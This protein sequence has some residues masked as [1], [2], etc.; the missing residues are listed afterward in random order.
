MAGFADNQFL[1]T[2]SG[3]LGGYALSG[4][5]VEWALMGALGGAAVPKLLSLAARH[6]DGRTPL[7]Q[8]HIDAHVALAYIARKPLNV[9]RDKLGDLGEGFVEQLK[10]ARNDNDR[11]LA[12]KYKYMR[13]SEMQ[14]KARGYT[15]EAILEAKHEAMEILKGNR[16]A[17]SNK[18]ANGMVRDW[19]KLMDDTLTDAYNSGIIDTEKYAR[20]KQ[21]ANQRGYFPRVYDE[22]FLNSEEGQDA[23]VKALSGKEVSEPK[24]R[25]LLQAVVGNKEVESQVLSK[26]QRRGGKIII[27]ENFAKIMLQ[28]RRS[29]HVG[30][31]SNHLEK[32]RK[33][34]S[35]FEELLA[36]FLVKDP[37]EA[38]SRYLLDSGNRINH[39]K[40][41]GAK[42]EKAH[43]IFDAIGKQYGTPAMRLAEEIYYARV[44]DTLST[45]V[46]AAVEMNDTWRTINGRVDAFETL[47]LAMGQVT[48]A[49][50]VPINASVLAAKLTGGSPKAMMKMWIDMADQLKSGKIRGED[51]AR[52]GAN[53]EATLM[54]LMGESGSM[55]HRIMGK[56]FSDIH[57]SGGKIFKNPVEYLN[58]PTEFLKKTGFLTVEDIN[59]ALASN[60]GRG[61]GQQLIDEMVQ[62]RKVGT[63]PSKRLIE[64]MKELGMDPHANSWGRADLD[65]AGLRFSDSVNFRNSPGELPILW[66]HPNAQ[67]FRKFKSFA[68]NHASFL[69]DNIVRPLYRKNIQGGAGAAAAYAVIGGVTGMGVDEV[70]RMVKGDDSDLTMTER[71]VRGV[72]AAG[73][74]GIWMDLM[75]SYNPLTSALGPAASDLD[76]LI[77]EGKQTVAG[78]QGPGKMISDLAKGTLVIPYEKQLF[79][80]INDLL[81][82]D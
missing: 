28:A 35:E 1:T 44:G 53:I 26:A 15:D 31:R 38:L 55:H 22:V 18:L 9:L 72:T 39:A 30:A 76:R 63:K 25:A 65:R 5:D 60:I 2:V 21:R 68:F 33:L 40:R 24:A 71:Y 27:D 80:E 41:F 34:P 43:V 81:N 8:A 58:N 57:T 19:R 45:N 52:M 69:M 56:S 3:G 66:Q 10:L 73:G 17:G 62:L 61:I 37:Y 82:L 47:K 20:L 23:W 4:G 6:P 74:L 46:K 77:R 67:A 70:K 49:G 50:Q 12:R 64:G 78:N 75:R 36:P 11:W 79:S 16:V 48:N 54:Q 42:D 7:S 13:N 29:K 51:A 59:R 32:G 14:A